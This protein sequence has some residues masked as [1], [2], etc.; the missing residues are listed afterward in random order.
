M[1]KEGGREV[2]DE[3]GYSSDGML[4]V[5]WCDGSGLIVDGRPEGVAIV[6]ELVDVGSMYY[7]GPSY[8][9]PSDQQLT[10]FS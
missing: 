9:A 8:D 3:I 6:L 4:W 1:F 5:D 10:M 7:M 2:W